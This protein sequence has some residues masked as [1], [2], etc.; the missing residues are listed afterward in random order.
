MPQLSGAPRKTRASFGAVTTAPRIHVE[1]HALGGA[2]AVV[3]PE[4]PPRSPIA[5]AYSPPAVEGGGLALY[6]GAKEVHCL[7]AEPA[8]TVLRV[9]V[10]DR[11][12]EVAYEAAVL[13]GIRSG[14]RTLQLRE[15]ESGT[16]I[17]L[18]SLFVHVD[19][20]THPHDWRTAT[21]VRS[22]RACPMRGARVLHR[23]A[24]ASSLAQEHEF[25]RQKCD[26][27][28]ATIREQEARLVERDELIGQLRAAAQ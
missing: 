20:G 22:P 8:Q 1:L 11:G 19:L 6:L 23:R 17:E 25:L 28:L 16:A 4:L 9:S 26:E 3:A 21:E 13:D 7:A 10:T 18:C 2:F 14:Y 24:V 27:Q 15:V 5:K 12:E